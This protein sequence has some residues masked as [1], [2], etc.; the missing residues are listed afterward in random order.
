MYLL[1]YERL[2][3]GKGEVRG[4]RRAG[5][6]ASAGW[7]DS[8]WVYVHARHECHVLHDY[9]TSPARESILVLKHTHWMSTDS[10]VIHRTQGRDDSIPY[11]MVMG[12]TIFKGL[13]A[14]TYWCVRCLSNCKDL[15]WK[16]TA[17]ITSAKSKTCLFYTLSHISDLPA[18]HAGIHNNPGR[19]QIGKIICAA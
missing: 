2:S 3:G 9:A 4:K 1:I 11:R 12:S 5:K 8:W 18:T 16:W 13:T 14:S 15:F 19:P 6:S 7:A 10:S 17:L